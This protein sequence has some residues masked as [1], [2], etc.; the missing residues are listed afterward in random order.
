MRVIPAIDV[1]D[2]CV[3]R[4]FKGRYDKV[5]RY[6][7]RPREYAEKVRDAGM[8]ALH[9]VDLDAARGDA[10]D[11]RAVVT[12]LAGIEGLEVQVGGGVRDEDRLVSMLEA[13]ASRVV[14]GS[15]AVRDP[16]RVV[17]WMNAVGP[18]RV[19]PALDVRIGAGG[20]PEAL[21]Q[22][23]QESGGKSLWEL[24]EI[25]RPAGMTEL[26]CTDVDR[27]GTLS[28][29]NLELYRDIVDR[30]DGIELQASGGVGSM[31]D[32]ELLAESGIPAVIV[33][34]AWLDGTISLPEVHSLQR[35][36]EPA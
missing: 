33:G 1:L 21:V 30:L 19:V 8:S 35:T 12:E 3:V 20:D 16:Q 27:D 7:M 4:L 13:G 25:Y 6:P 15:M 14:V 26:L 23:W 2:G 24:L 5:T 34:R 28:G 32:I 36:V 31:R 10:R 18:E 9:V 11:N 22:G 29:P 17:H